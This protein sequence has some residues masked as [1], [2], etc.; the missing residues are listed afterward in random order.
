MDTI[1]A[2]TLFTVYSKE[3]FITYDENDRF[4]AS[5]AWQGYATDDGLDTTQI[6]LSIDNAEN[7]TPFRQI[8]LSKFLRIT[9]DDAHNPTEPAAG[10]VFGCDAN[11]CDVVLDENQRRGV[12]RKQFAIEPDWDRGTLIL[13]NLSKQGTF[14]ESQSSGRTWLHSEQSLQDNEILD[15]KIGKVELHIRIPDHSKHRNVFLEGWSAFRV[16]LQSQ[17]SGLQKLSLETNKTTNKSQPTDYIYQWAIGRG[18]QATVYEAV[19]QPSGQKFA[20]KE[21]HKVHSDNLKELSILPRIQHENIVKLHAIETRN[22]TEVIVMELGGPSLEEV[23]NKKPLTG[24]EIQMGMKQLLGALD[25]LHGINITHRDIK[26]SNIIVFSRNPLHLKFTDFGLASTKSEQ[27]LKS[28]VGTPRYIAPEVYD[29]EYYTN[30]MD[31]WSLGAVALQ[32]FDKLPNSTY[33]GNVNLSTLPT[34]PIHVVKHVATRYRRNRTWQFIHSLLQIDPELR[35]S[36][37]ESLES[38]FFTAP[39]ESIGLFREARPEEPTQVFNPPQQHTTPASENASETSTFI[40]DTEPCSLARNPQTQTSSREPATT[41]PEAGHS[42]RSAQS[43]SQQETSCELSTLKTDHY[44]QDKPSPSYHEIAPH[45]LSRSNSRNDDDDDDD[46]DDSSVRLLYHQD[47]LRNPL[48]VGSFVAKMGQESLSTVIEQEE[49]EGGVK[50][51]GKGKEKEGGV[52][53]EKEKEKEKEEEEEENSRLPT[54]D[55]T[56]HFGS[57]NHVT[58]GTSLPAQPDDDDADPDYWDEPVF[59]GSRYIGRGII[60]THHSISRPTNVDSS[61]SEPGENDTEEDDDDLT[62]LGP[63][64]TESF[65]RQFESTSSTST[66]N[67]NDFYPEP[68]ENHSAIQDSPRNLIEGQGEGS[69]VAYAP[70]PGALEDLGTRS[71]GLG[72]GSSVA[73]APT[74]GALEDLG[75]RSIGLGE[76]SS[77]AYAPTPGALEDL[78]TRSIGLG[79]GSS[80]A[81]APTPGALEDL[82]TRSIGLG[83]GSTSSTST[84]NFYDFYP[85]SRENH[86]AIQDSPRNPIEGQG[87]GSSVAYAPTPGAL[88]DLGARSIGPG[89]G[90][91]SFS[92]NVSLSWSSNFN[93]ELEQ[94]FLAMLTPPHEAVLPSIEVDDEHLH[95]VSSTQ[96]R[97]SRKRKRI[98]FHDTTYLEGMFEKD[99]QPDEKAY[100]DIA[101]F[102]SLNKSMVMEWYKKQRQ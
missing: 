19:H 86:S 76:G 14:I 43:S 11:V 62:V 101:E 6:G 92:N 91:I 2:R 85:E 36:A 30:K 46:D 55:Y 16:R 9:V 97:G 57:T 94:E 18:S 89:E 98:G 33:S 53:K 32:L 38:T 59:P 26:P 54:Y 8:G 45:A 7:G 73:Y 29:R 15:I 5:D 4:F 39:H 100:T 70:T 47:P 77:V 1:A 48:Y 52:E 12:S 27:D 28:F 66:R 95:S 42:V 68:R 20:I 17:I 56:A 83:E 64:T 3:R 37:K 22:G 84:R 21:F 31:I 78:G 67:F 13:R 88:E 90:R 58:R 65:Y 82:G 24:A 35:P 71:I 102:L 49:E 87:E 41:P 25:Y 81:Y 23:M 61:A 96:E 75:T 50:E 69:S 63:S 80:V 74:P 72:E 99:S 34:W 93:R 51:E 44:I 60:G 10:F 40:P 79:E